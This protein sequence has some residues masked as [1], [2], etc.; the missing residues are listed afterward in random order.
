LTTLYS[1]FADSVRR[2]RSAIAQI[3]HDEIVPCTVHFGEFSY[4]RSDTFHADR[5][6]NHK[7]NIAVL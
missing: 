2:R 5:N 3:K 7:S 4:H 6:A 1:L